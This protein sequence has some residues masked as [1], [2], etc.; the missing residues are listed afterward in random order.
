MLSSANQQFKNLFENS[1]WIGCTYFVHKKN[2][3]DKLDF[4]SIKRNF[5]GYSI[6]KNDYKYY[7]SK[8]KRTF[9]L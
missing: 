1:L 4:T 2:K 8:N 3:L 5:L 9:Y 6:L 7:G